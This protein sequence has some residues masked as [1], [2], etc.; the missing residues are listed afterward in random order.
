MMAKMGMAAETT[1]IVGLWWGA[2]GKLQSDIAAYPAAAFETV[3]E[4]ERFAELK[5]EFL[6]AAMSV[7]LA[8]V[9]RAM[10]S[11]GARTTE[12]NGVNYPLTHMKKNLGVECASNRS[13]R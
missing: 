10:T 1:S 11:T 2:D 13:R 12:S 8:T 7:P 3:A 5:K 6:D 9:P 4:M